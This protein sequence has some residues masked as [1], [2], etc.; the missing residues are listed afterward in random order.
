ME[1]IQLYSYQY[2]FKL[3]GVP[4]IDPDKKTSDTVD[5]R[6]KVFS[7]IRADIYIRY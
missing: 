6:L 1:N 2:N 3:V 7:G 4:E 5:V